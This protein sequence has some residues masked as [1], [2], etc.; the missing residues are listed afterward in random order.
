MNATIWI[1]ALLSLSLPA[2][3][4][5]GDNTSERVSLPGPPGYYATEEFRSWQAPG[6]RS[7]Y[8]FFWVPQAPRDLGP[9][10]VAA[11]WPVRVAG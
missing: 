11:E 8:L 7:L 5:L 2:E 6:D 10:V 4:R 9:L 1:V 3:Y